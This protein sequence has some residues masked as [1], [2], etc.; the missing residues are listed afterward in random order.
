[1]AKIYVVSTS[2]K[3]DTHKT[4]RPW[5][6]DQPQGAE[7]FIQHK[8]NAWQWAKECIGTGQIWCIIP[9]LMHRYKSNSAQVMQAPSELLASVWWW[10]PWLGPNPRPCRSLHGLKSDCWCQLF[11]D[12]HFVSLSCELLVLTKKTACSTSSHFYP[13]VHLATSRNHSLVLPKPSSVSTTGK[14]WGSDDGFL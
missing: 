5:L 11:V 10:A 13:R 9:R 1:M 14:N 6:Q 4:S 3:Y 8:M 2:N 12:E 7:T